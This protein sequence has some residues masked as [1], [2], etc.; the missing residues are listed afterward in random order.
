MRRRA[1]LAAVGATAVAGC[2]G[3]TGS[4]EPNDPQTTDPETTD[5][6][7]TDDSSDYFS[8]RLDDVE[9]AAP[10]AEDVSVDVSIVENFTQDH[11]ATLRVA[12]TNEADEE[13][14]FEFGSLV[15]WDTIRG[16]RDEGPGIL[17]LDPNAGVAPD[18][19]TDNCWRATDKVALPAVMRSKTLAAGETV[20]REFAVLAAHDS[21]TCHEQGTYRFEDENYLDEGFW[22]EVTVVPIVEAD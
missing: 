11:P 19:P 2:T 7:T 12:F 10:P 3:V 18:E 15:P 22:F 16:Q 21:E 20:S 13:R 17:L 14:T 8:Y 9:T 4:E 6:T 1:F 5:P